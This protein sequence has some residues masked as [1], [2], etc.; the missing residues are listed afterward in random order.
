[1]VIVDRSS[2]NVEPDDILFLN[3]KGFGSLNHKKGFSSLR[4]EMWLIRTNWAFIANNL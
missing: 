2:F 3:L 1:V 4:K